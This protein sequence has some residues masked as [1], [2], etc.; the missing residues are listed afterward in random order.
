MFQDEWVISR[1]FQK[2]GAAVA[3]G[4]KRKMSTS[5]NLYPE[6]S[7]PS[8]VSLP[9]LV[10]SSSYNNTATSAPAID[11]ESCSYD[12]GHNATKEHV[13]CFSTTAPQSFNPNVSLFDLPA[14]PL[15]AANFSPLLDPSSTRFARNNNV[16]VPAFP[17]L[18]SL[19]ENL[20]LP[21]FFPGA[22]PTMHGGLADQMGG[23]Y[24]SSIP[25]W[26]AAT[27][28]QKVGS[29]ELDCMWSY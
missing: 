16:G 29:S 17:S 25:S 8:S 2:T 11:N 19:Q 20:H 5:I 18:R 23:G 15:A 12:G 10:E 1:V 27:E 6:V 26:P 14:P 3:G 22:T 9:P 7:S 13:P 4:G 21:F 28:S 24:G